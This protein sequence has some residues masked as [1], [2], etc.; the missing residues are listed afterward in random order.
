MKGK[1][2]IEKSF[3]ICFLAAVIVFTMIACIGCSREPASESS[4]LQSSA[5]IENTETASE[6]IGRA[7]CRERV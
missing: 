3:R 2:D 4:A 1:F 5:C 7:S 6:E